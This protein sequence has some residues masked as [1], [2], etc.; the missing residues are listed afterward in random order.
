MDNK[1]NKV[2]LEFDVTDL[3]MVADAFSIARNTA[4]MCGRP[5]AKERLE[6]LRQAVEALV[7]EPARVFD[8]EVWA[9]IGA[10]LSTAARW[11]LAVERPDWRGSYYRTGWLVVTVDGKRWKSDGSEHSA[12]GPEAA[13]VAA[14]LAEL[15]PVGCE[16]DPDGCRLLPE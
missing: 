7:P 2:S 11:S 3:P 1:R 9:E 8:G 5:V 10:A 12:A 16:R 13:A 14:L 4:M 6:R 15:A